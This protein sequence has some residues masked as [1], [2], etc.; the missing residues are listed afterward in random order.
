MTLKAVLF[1][2]D[3]TLVDSNYHHVVCWYRAFRE[4]GHLVTAARIHH[5]IGLA[6]DDLVKELIGTSDSSLDDRHGELLHAMSDQIGP[7]PGAEQLLRS[8]REAGLEVVLSTS[9][10]A[11]D[12]EWMLPLI[13]GRENVSAVLSSSE[14]DETKP[15]PLP[16][17]AAADEAGA[18][19]NECL[20]I[21]DSVWDMRS[22][23]SGGFVAIGLTGGG[24]PE[25]DL[26]EAGATATFA[27]PKDLTVTTLQSFL[28]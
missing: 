8:C 27:E 6:G 25:P 7:L 20:V 10:G 11:D 23:T 26:M 9:A 21:G 15:H 1:D 19:V 5:A 17:Q 22:A 2:V 12:L 13:G 3:G 16:F 24:T 4:A 14:L 28:S 18:D